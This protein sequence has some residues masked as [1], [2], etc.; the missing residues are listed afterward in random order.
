[1]TLPLRVVEEGYGEQPVSTPAT[2]PPQVQLLPSGWRTRRMAFGSGHRVSRARFPAEI[3]LNLPE[4]TMDDAAVADAKTDN[5]D[6]TS[7]RVRPLQPLPVGRRYDLVVDGICDAYGGRPLP[8]PQVFP[9][10]TTRPLGIDYVAARNFPLESPRIEVKFTQLL[11][12]ASLPH[13]ALKI[14]PAIANVRLRKDGVF[15]IAEGVFIPG[16]GYVVTVSE[17]ILGANGY[18][19]LKSET[20]NASVR[21]KESAILFPAQQIRERSALGLNF[22]FYQ[23]NTGEL[24]WKL[25]AV[26][27][28][29]LPS[30]VSREREFADFLQDE[31]GNRLWTTEGTFQ[32]QTSEP[33]VPGLG[34][35]VMAS[36]KIAAAGED[37]ETLRE[38]TWKPKDP[39]VLAGPKLVEI[40]GKDAQ[41]RSIGNRATPT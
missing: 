34:L 9:V 41:G 4:A 18:G 10:G 37:T 19:L 11:G 33:L 22:A 28:D 12:D 2:S 6:V 30:V 17:K 38:L 24:E 27:L 32:R 31:R 20:W 23:V 39:T 21:S 8:Y 35:T 14:S 29:K 5:A 13:D 36:G 25:A 40:T 3:L 26:P 16:S 7:F 1:M 15:L